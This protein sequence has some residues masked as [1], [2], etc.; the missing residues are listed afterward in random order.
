MLPAT[1]KRHCQGVYVQVHNI[2]S[3]NEGAWSDLNYLKVTKGYIMCLLVNIPYAILTIW[4][5]TLAT[6]FVSLHVQ[7]QCLPT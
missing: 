3:F 7:V 5:L 6:I 1:Y 2:S 4:L